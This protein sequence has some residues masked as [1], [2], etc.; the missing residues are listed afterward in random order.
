MI[1]AGHIA[2]KMAGIERMRVVRGG[3]RCACKN[4]QIAKS[5]IYRL[6]QAFEFS[7][8]KQRK[9]CSVLS[10]LHISMSQ[11]ALN[12]LKSWF[13]LKWVYPQR[14][15]TVKWF[16]SDDPKIRS[17]SPTIN[18]IWPNATWDF[19]FCCHSND[20]RHLHSRSRCIYLIFFIFQIAMQSSSFLF[21]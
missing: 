9:Y 18:L 12:I 20:I 7:D 13:F 14:K 11:V 16:F 5:F 6:S 1:M 3:V 10:L 19:W 4:R 8:S 21:N 15:N 2:A 17:H